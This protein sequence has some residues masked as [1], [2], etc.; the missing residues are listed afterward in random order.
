MK[1]VVIIDDELDSLQIMR[2]V[3]EE[4]TCRVFTA[5]TGGQGLELVG[6]SNPDLVFLDLRLPDT[7]GELLLPKIKAAC[8]RAKVIIGTAYGD[9]K[10]RERLLQ[11]GADGFFDKPID[12]NAFE[13]KARQLIGPLSEIRLLVIDDEP[14]FC[15]DLKEILEND[16]ESKW[17]VHYATSGEE[18]IRKVEELMHDL[19]TLDICLN[20]KGDTRPLSSGLGVYRELKRKGYKIP[21]VVLASYIDSAD[22]EELNK[23]GLSTVYSKTEVMGL[24]TT[25]HF[26][27]VLKRIALR[28]AYSPKIRDSHD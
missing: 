9:Q 1:R 16:G 12:L 24:A 13:K 8:P 18:G 20:I 7:D 14:Y 21:V 17:I 11:N 2:D 19:I 27:N 10:I 25:T 15:K 5:T 3:L 4:Y 6:E 22:A 26:L 23:E 28:G